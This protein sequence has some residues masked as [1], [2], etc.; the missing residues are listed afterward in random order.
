MKDYLR[1]YATAAFRFYA[2]KKMTAEQYKKKI[3]NEAL[4]QQRKLEKESGISCPTEAAIIRAE[5]AVNEKLAEIR[6]MEAVE[7]TL[8]EL[9]GDSD[10]YE[11]TLR[12]CR[13]ERREIVQ[14]V[15]IV[16]FADPEKELESGDIYNRVHKAEINIPA[17]ERSIYYYLKKA[18]L[19]FAEN[20]GL[21]TDQ[22]DLAKSLQ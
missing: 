9:N 11:N 13:H 15:E 17:S 7:L 12:S 8:A 16:Y 14:A 6:D 20:R 5:A 18:R 21:R 22:K 4:E 10:F 3:Y 2:S 1:D 19:L